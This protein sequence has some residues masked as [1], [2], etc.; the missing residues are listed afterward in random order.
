[1]VANIQK[2]NNETNVFKNLSEF[3]NITE[4]GEILES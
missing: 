1:M 3:L 4:Y 2:S